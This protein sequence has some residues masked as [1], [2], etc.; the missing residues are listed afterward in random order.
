[1][2]ELMRAYMHKFRELDKPSWGDEPQVIQEFLRARRG[3]QDDFGPMDTLSTAVVYTDDSDITV[4]GPAE[5]VERANFA[6]YCSFGEGGAGMILADAMKWLISSHSLSCG[7]RTAPTL[8]IL[9]FDESKRVKAIARIQL[10]L[11]G[12]LDADQYRSL[13]S[14]IA[15]VNSIIHEHPYMVSTLWQPITKERLAEAEGQ[16]RLTSEERGKLK[17]WRKR[18]TTCPGTTL[19]RHLK[20]RRPPTQAQTVQWI[21][22]SDAM[23]GWS[24]EGT[25]ECGLGGAIHGLLWSIQLEAAEWQHLCTT[26]LAEYMAHGIGLILLDELAPEAAD[27]VLEVDAVAAVSVDEDRADSARI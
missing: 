12:K 26:P 24:G 5:R 20:Q 6:V 9:W 23:L 4:L 7:V 18:M 16:V 10:T 22:V 14:Y 25:W 8:G 19:A 2:N 21:S 3:M 11:V 15:Y 13:V 17:Y 1:M 27:I